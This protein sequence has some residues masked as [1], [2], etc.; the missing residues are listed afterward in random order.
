MQFPVVSIQHS[1][2]DTTTWEAAEDCILAGFH[3]T[4]SACVSK[5][6]AD[7]ATNS[8][9]PTAKRLTESIIIATNTT[10]IKW[11]PVAIPISKGSRLVVSTTAAG[12]L[13]MFFQLTPEQTAD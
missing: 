4:V 5:D 8:I 12:T 9:T 13:S 1:A 10:G 7:T 11:I 2:A 3:T 6:P